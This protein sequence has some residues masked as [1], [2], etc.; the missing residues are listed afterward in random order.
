MTCAHGFIGPCSECDGS[1]QQ[2][3]L[4]AAGPL[5]TCE[6]CGAVWISSWSAEEAEAEAHENFGVSRASTHSGM[7]QVCTPCFEAI[8]QQLADEGEKPQPQPGAG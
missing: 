3:E 5:C 1:G 7:A 8:M 6:S 4:E 2:P